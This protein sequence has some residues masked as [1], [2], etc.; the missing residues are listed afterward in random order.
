MEE[1]LCHAGVM[2]M[3]AGTLC[4][5]GDAVKA[6]VAGVE[7]SYNYTKLGK[8]GYPKNKRYH[9][10]RIGA[11][12]GGKVFDIKKQ[13]QMEYDGLM[14]HAWQALWSRFHKQ[15]LDDIDGVLE[16]QSATDDDEEEEAEV[17]KNAISPIME[18]NSQVSTGSATSTSAQ[19]CPSTPVS[20]NRVHVLDTP[21]KLQFGALRIEENLDPKDFPFLSKLEIS[22]STDFNVGVILRE[23][24]LLCTK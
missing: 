12:K 7:N 18:S 15:L 9:C 14:E 20:E 11:W 10:I 22:L 13:L 2:Y 4:V 8:F 19:A 3:K 6:L 16:L 5:S 21:M 1:Y 24:D 17:E 23:I